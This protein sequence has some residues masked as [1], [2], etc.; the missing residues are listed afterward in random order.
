MNLYLISQDEN[1][2]Y[3]T[4][5]SAVIVSENEESARN[6]CIGGD[7]WRQIEEERKKNPSYTGYWAS[8]PKNVKAKWVGIASPDLKESEIVCASFNAG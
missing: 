8:S 3:D 1:N 5:D 7:T 6:R 4:Y 2:G